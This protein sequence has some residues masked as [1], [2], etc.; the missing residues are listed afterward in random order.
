MS[1]TVMLAVPSSLSITQE[2]VTH[3]RGSSSYRRKW[4]RRYQSEHKIAGDSQL[5]LAG[6]RFALLQ[7]SKRSWSPSQERRQLRIE[8]SAKG[9]R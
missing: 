6:V 1:L 9:R 3:R 8:K 5:T 2:V 7:G 4:Y